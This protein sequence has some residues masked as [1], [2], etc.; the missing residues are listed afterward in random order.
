MLKC[1][2]ENARIAIFGKDDKNRL[3]DWPSDSQSRI[4]NLAAAAKILENSEPHDLVRLRVGR[5]GE[6]RLETRFALGRLLSHGA[7]CSN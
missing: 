2:S 1:L 5:A 3:P 4:F 6:L 7:R